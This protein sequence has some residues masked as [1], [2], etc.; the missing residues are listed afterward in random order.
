MRA[1]SRIRSVLIAL[2]LAACA[3]T[4]APPVDS[5]AFAKRAPLP[6]QP[7][8]LETIR[9]IADGL[10]YVSSGA[11]FFVSSNGEMCFEGLPDADMNP[12]ANY[13]NFWCISPMAVASVDTVRNGVTYVNGVR[14][15]CRHSEP[16]CAHKIGYPNM[17]DQSWIANSILAET[18]PFREQRAAIQHLIYLMGGNVGEPEPLAWRRNAA[19]DISP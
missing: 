12:Y 17:L 10:R 9:F 1:T 16:Q 8:Y 18:I 3:P 2:L 7:G 13:R 19:L 15:W 6:G 11:T 5:P 4:P 14:L